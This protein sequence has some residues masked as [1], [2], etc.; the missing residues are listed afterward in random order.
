MHVQP[1]HEVF[2]KDCPER[3]IPRNDG[4]P[5]EECHTLARQ[6]HRDVIPQ[7]MQDH[8]PKMT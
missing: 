5:R 3:D 8:E 4:G 1:Y 7:P 6:H 2:Q